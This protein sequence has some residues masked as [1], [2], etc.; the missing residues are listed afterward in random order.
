M[1]LRTQVAALLG[2]LLLVLT[3]TT[4]S[5]QRIVVMP[6]FARLETQAA[7]RDLDRCRDAIGRDI[8]L[9]SHSALDWSAWDSVYDYAKTKNNEFESSSLNDEVFQHA[10]INCLLILGSYH[11]IVWG[12]FV[13]FETLER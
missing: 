9:L 10:H 3:A 6:T 1:S 12:L 7:E 5:V 8:Q 11:K 4:Y 13:D 2:V